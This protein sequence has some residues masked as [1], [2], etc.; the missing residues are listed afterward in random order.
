MV[1]ITNDSKKKGNMVL[2]TMERKVS[3]IR[4]ARRIIAYNK[5]IMRRRSS[6][7]RDTSEFVRVRSRAEERVDGWLSPQPIT[8]PSLIRLI[9][10]HTKSLL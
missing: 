8:V 5:L 1:R 4:F 7:A 2:S 6:Y 3:R 10:D 9:E